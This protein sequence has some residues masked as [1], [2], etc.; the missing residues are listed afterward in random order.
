[1]ENTMRANEIEE[2]EAI[3]VEE[4]SESSNSGAL[5]AGIVG[6]FLAYAMIGGARKLKA[7]IDFKRA[8]KNAEAANKEAVIVETHDTQVDS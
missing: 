3:E 4:A 5:F 7:F 1:M 6:G 8:V 2:I